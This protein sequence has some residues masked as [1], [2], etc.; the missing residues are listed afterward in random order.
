MQMSFP[1]RS[2]NTCLDSGLPEKEF[3]G[4]A[5]KR[6]EGPI[7]SIN[8]LRLIHPSENRVE[9][10]QFTY[11]YFELFWCIYYQLFL[12]AHKGKMTVLL[13]RFLFN[14]YLKCVVSIAVHSFCTIL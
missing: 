11:I 13:D 10:C 4:G 9:S 1:V 8:R 6:A 3:K 7:S 2:T 5:V 14:F 12:I